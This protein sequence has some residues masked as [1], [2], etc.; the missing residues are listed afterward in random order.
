MCSAP[1]GNAAVAITA[2]LAGYEPLR[3]EIQPRPGKSRRLV[4]RLR[5]KKVI[6]NSVGMTLVLIPAGEFMMGSPEEG[7]SFETP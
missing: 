6:T 5:R 1:D 2:T 7:G 4:L 3:E